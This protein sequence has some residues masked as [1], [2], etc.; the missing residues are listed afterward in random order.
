MEKDAK[1]L[2]I[3]GDSRC[4]FCDATFKA[5]TRTTRSVINKHIKTMARKS[6]SEER[7]NHPRIGTPAFVKIAKQRGFR[8]VASSKELQKLKETARKRKWRLKRKKEN[9][10]ETKLNNPL[11][12]DSL[13]VELSMEQQMPRAID[14]KILA[15][16]ET[17]FERLRYV[18]TQKLDCCLL[19]IITRSDIEDPEII[20]KPTLYDNPSFPELAF[21][22]LPL[23]TCLNQNRPRNSPHLSPF[24]LN[25]RH[26][27]LLR[28][29]CS[30]NV[31]ESAWNEWQ[32]LKGS[33]EGETQQKI[34]WERAKE[35]KSRCDLYQEVWN[36]LHSPDPETRKLFKY[37]CFQ[38]GV[39][40][41]KS[42]LE[43][44][45]E[46]E[47][48]TWDTFKD[49]EALYERLPVSGRGCAG[50]D[51]IHAEK[52]V[53]ARTPEYKPWRKEERVIYGTPEC[54]PWKE[55]ERVI[56]G[57]PE[58]ELRENRVASRSPEL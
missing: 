15:R 16:I 31:L 51:I 33:Q 43:R 39:V 21:H 23:E 18:T 42:L 54:E 22:Y 9:A 47:A 44:G 28:H 36:G 40:E 53:C 46:W 57:N 45:V 7:G 25:D 4:P 55:E 48:L 52:F 11:D 17:A 32:M 20:P 6:E 26:F 56:Y 5:G 30:K 2:S 1:N 41:L 3:P 38:R 58:L 14:S 34:Q 35:M 50:Q 29:H 8:E 19:R 49:F 13:E 27:L 24:C 10:T 12:L 37:Q